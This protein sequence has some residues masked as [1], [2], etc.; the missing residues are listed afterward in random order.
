MP[1]LERRSNISIPPD[2]AVYYEAVA[3]KQCRQIA[4]LT[5][6][7]E[8]MRLG[9]SASTNLVV[10]LALAQDRG[11]FPYPRQLWMCAK[12]D[13]LAERDALEYLAPVRG[14]RVLQI[15]GQG[16]HAVQFMLGGAREAWL[17][18]PVESEARYARELA[19]LARVEIRCEIGVAEDM[20]FASG[21]FEAIYT[22]G[23]AHHFETG[24]A[25]PE[26]A[27]VLAARGRFS[28][29]EPWRAP[30]YAWG[31]RMFGK[32]EKE[33]HCRPLDAERL[34][35]LGESFTKFAVVQHGTFTR[36]PMLALEKMGFG[37]PAGL[38]W[39]LTEFDDR[40]ASR[41]GLRAH[42]SSVAIMAEKHSD[43]S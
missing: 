27:R 34:A 24:K 41:L 38:A 22:A 18:T 21:F 35:P 30:L 29:E 28:A 19:R 8:L 9:Q 10:R 33:V 39:K 43:I 5:S 23:C 13:C 14:K 31:I 32:R 11:E 37:V 6:I 40:L 36:Y 26:I 16:H 12:Y 15:G 4:H 1:S 20:P 3:G 2:E 25:F 17:L 42:G 7:T